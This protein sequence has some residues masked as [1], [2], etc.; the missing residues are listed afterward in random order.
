MNPIAAFLGDAIRDAL[1]F[2]VAELPQHKKARKNHKLTT[3][4]NTRIFPIEQLS[5][6]LKFLTLVNFRFTHQWGKIH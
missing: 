2:K 5:H 6:K 1:S 4:I 3:I